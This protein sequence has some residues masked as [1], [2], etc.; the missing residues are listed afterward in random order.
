M[1]YVVNPGSIRNFEYGTV[2]LDAL[3]AGFVHEASNRIEGFFSSDSVP[4]MF[5]EVVIII[6]V[7]N[8]VLSSCKGNAAKRI[9]KAE[10]PV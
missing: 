7:D 10:E 2:H 9:S 1:I 6:G 4:S 3:S 8:G 5:G